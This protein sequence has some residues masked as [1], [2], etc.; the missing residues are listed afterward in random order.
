M[1]SSGYPCSLSE[2]KEKPQGMLIY[3]NLPGRTPGVIPGDAPVGMRVRVVKR[4]DARHPLTVEFGR[5]R[6][7]RGLFRH[8]P[9]LGELAEPDIPSRTLPRAQ[10]GPL[11]G[12]GTWRTRSGWPRRACPSAPGG[13][14]S[15]HR[16]R[17][18][19]TT[20]SHRRPV[21]AIPVPQRRACWLVWTRHPGSGRSEASG[22][23]SMSR[24]S[25]GSWNSPSARVIAKTVRAPCW[26]IRT[27]PPLSLLQPHVAK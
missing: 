10:G 6:G 21:C 11:P 12:S 22:S 9:R 26:S 3:I 27:C 1:R 18:R 5:R 19:P 23:H 17:H 7:A 13:L 2:K 15:P 20:E 8:V 16:G 25:H 14:G 4:E 24:D